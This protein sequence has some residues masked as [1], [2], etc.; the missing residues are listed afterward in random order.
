MA[1]AIQINEGKGKKTDR[2]AMVM[3][4]VKDSSG[5]IKE[6]VHKQMSLGEG[7]Q[8]RNLLNG[9]PFHGIIFKAKL[10]IVYKNV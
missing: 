5:N 10:L 9:V 8:K 3:M 7:A 1:F 6:M 2:F 4:C